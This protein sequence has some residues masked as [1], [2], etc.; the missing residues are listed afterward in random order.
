MCV[1]LFGQYL[2]MT[3]FLGMTISGDFGFWDN[4]VGTYF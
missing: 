4:A 1:A 3:V 2:R